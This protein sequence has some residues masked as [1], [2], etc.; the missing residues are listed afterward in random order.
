MM[1][2]M[3]EDIVKAI[4]TAFKITDIEVDYDYRPA[5]KESVLELIC[6][7]LE[8]EDADFTASGE[9]WVYK[10]KVGDDYHIDVLLLKRGVELQFILPHSLQERR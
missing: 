10:S 6:G 4:K 1:A 3:I 9:T 8:D 7:V 5:S 2:D